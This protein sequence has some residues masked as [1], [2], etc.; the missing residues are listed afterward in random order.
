MADY[1][2]SATLSRVVDGD[3]CYLRLEKEFSFDIDFGF[4]ILDKMTLK[5]STV[6]DFRLYG[7]NTPEMKTPDGPKAKA[8]LTRLLGLGTLRVV[9][10][11]AD[12]Y[13][14]WLADIYV[15]P[16]GEPELHVNKAL[17]DGGFAVVYLP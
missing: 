4:N 10:H 15:K 17:V 2:Y 14:R 5:K 12:K 13:G 7:I 16:A 6:M 8:E 1:E 11:K 3:T 9:S